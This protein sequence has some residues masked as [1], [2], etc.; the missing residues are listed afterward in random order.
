MLYEQ[1]LTFMRPAG[2][3]PANPVSER[4]KIVR[5]LHHMTSEIR[6]SYPSYLTSPAPLNC[7]GTKSEEHP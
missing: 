5:V 3:K 7:S 4:Q 2:F 6:K 1:E